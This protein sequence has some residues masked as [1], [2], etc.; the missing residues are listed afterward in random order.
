[1][2]G[3]HQTIIVGNVGRIDDPGLRYT[4]SGIAVMSFSVAVTEKWGKGNERQEKT[5]WYKVSMWRG[6]AEALAQYITV[7]TQV[8]VVGNV[9]TD[10]YMNNNNQP[11]ASLKLTARDI[12]LLGTKGGNGNSGGG[13]RQESDNDFGPPPPYESDDIPF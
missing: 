12:Q 13:N 7:G 9:E 1:M 2:A 4:Q 6:L 3:W 5:T 10:A 11:A 8:M